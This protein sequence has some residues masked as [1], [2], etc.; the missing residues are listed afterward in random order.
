[1]AYARQLLFAVLVLGCAACKSRS[2][3]ASLGA[4][5]VVA[6]FDA[7]QLP[8]GKGVVWQCNA[9]RMKVVYDGGDKSDLGD[10][11][12]H[13]LEQRGWSEAQGPAGT[14]HQ[15]LARFE[16]GHE[17]LTLDVHD[18]DFR[19]KVPNGVEVFLAVSDTP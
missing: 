17:T 6:P 19:G 15:W 10:R 14:T 11:Y 16:K 2:G 9:A 18:A 7:M 12:G 5:P 1:V 4:V 3:A 13:A 8:I